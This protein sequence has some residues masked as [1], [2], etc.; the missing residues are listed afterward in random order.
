MKEKSMTPQKTLGETTTLRIATPY[1]LYERIERAA[2]KDNRKIS[3]FVRLFLDK[4]L[5]K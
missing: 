5:P 4:H 3:A 2:L 1:E